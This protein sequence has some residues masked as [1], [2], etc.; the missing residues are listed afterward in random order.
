MPELNYED[1]L[2]WCSTTL[3]NSRG[4]L[5]ANIRT[6][7]K[8]TAG[9]ICG[10]AHLI[11]F[12]LWQAC[13]RDRNAFALGEARRLARG[14]SRQPQRLR[15]PPDFWVGEVDALTTFGL[16]AMSAMMLC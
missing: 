2:K 5:M 1:A 12:A 15:G 7:L 4:Y 14:A 16:L 6:V 11:A 13:G 9:S 8:L 3:Y 10:W